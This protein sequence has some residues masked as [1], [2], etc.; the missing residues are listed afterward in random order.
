VVFV[1]PFA[2]ESCIEYFK[3]VRHVK[4]FGCVSRAVQL[5]MLETTAPCVMLTVDDCVILPGSI[6]A[7]MDFFKDTCHERDVINLR[8]V[9]GGLAWTPDMCKAGSH[10]ELCLP[11]INPEWKIA[12]QFIMERLTFLEMGGFDCRYEYINE[13]VHDFMFRLQR[14]GGKI[15]DSPTHCCYA[16]HYPGVTKDHGPIHYAQT[17][18]DYP[19]FKERWTNNDVATIIDYNNWK[20]QPAVWTRRFSKG[21]VGSYEELIKS[22]GYQF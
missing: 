20:Q 6:D 17:S 7:A 12:M 2:D 14:D 5:G 21:Q 19:I 16:T 4:E 3:H 15:Y 1:G 18:H 9:E 13:P 11:N 22:E 10:A 8:Y